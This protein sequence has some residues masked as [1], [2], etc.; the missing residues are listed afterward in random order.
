MQVHVPTWG[1]VIDFTERNPFDPEVNIDLGTTILADYLKRYKDL[2]TA[3]AAYEGTTIPKR[4]SI[5][6]VMEVYRPGSRPIHKPRNDSDSGNPVE[7]LHRRDIREEIIT[8]EFQP[9]QQACPS[10]DI[11]S[12]WYS[13]SRG[14][15]SFNFG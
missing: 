4:A 15:N 12:R 8:P 9:P 11:L 7:L 3:L 5:A 1:G 14:N 10:V 2:D 13:I 6:K